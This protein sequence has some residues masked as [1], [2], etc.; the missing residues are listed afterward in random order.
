MSFWPG[1][2]FYWTVSLSFREVRNRGGEGRVLWV[3]LGW[4]M[5][6][7]HSLIYAT[8]QKCFQIG[9]DNQVSPSKGIRKLKRPIHSGELLNLSNKYA[10]DGRAINVRLC[11]C[12]AV[13][14][15][16]KRLRLAIITVT[17]PSLRRI[18]LERKQTI[19]LQYHLHVRKSQYH[20]MF[21]VTFHGQ[22]RCMI[23]DED[24][25]CLFNNL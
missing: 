14:C 1:S 15:L 22:Y 5:V 24:M 23:Q 2:C 11:V 13:A 12:L 7:S 19:Y 16:S 6:G 21:L 3:K 25:W 17:C 18:F 10:Q 20:F 8:L 4:A 9:F